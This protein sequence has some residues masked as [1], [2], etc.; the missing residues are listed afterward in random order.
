MIDGFPAAFAGSDRGARPLTWSSPLKSA[1][2]PSFE[3]DVGRE[4]LQ[5][6]VLHH[7]EGGRS[8]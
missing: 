1:R 8:P 4:K 6:Q 3:A 2:I 7:D 5:T